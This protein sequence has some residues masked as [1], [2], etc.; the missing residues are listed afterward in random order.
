[1]QTRTTIKITLLLCL[2]SVMNLKA[3]I[4]VGTSAP[5]AA[6]DI[7]STTQGVLIP[8]LAALQAEAISNPELGELIYSTTN[9][10]V[11]IKSQGFWYY[12]GTTWKPFGATVQ[13]NIDLY[14]GNGTLT[15]NRTVTMSGNNLSFDSDK[16]TILS[17]AQ[18][19]GLGNNTP[20][21][22]LDVNGNTR[23]R[24]LSAGNVVSL[25]DGT[26]ALGPKVPYGTVKESLRST[27]HNGWYKLDGRAV[28]TLSATAQARA[29]TLGITGNLINASN[30][31]MRQG[32]TLASGGA[33]NVTLIRANLPNYNM[34]GTTSTS[35]DQ[36]HTMIATGF[37]LTPNA[38]GNAFIVRAGRG[39]ASATATIT[40]ASA[41]AHIHS[42]NITSGGTGTPFSI[43]PESITYTYFIYLGQ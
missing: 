28:N 26:L 14:N 19:V 32:A 38:A 42:G 11:T 5:K 6:L 3:Q 13:P 40:V 22:T 1:M 41:G 17:T 31:L 24:N 15:S 34:T 20:Q 43:I 18:R 37:N 12:D 2:F 35:A 29:A 7:T 39:T 8:R 21:H 23:V 36:T 33:S 10:G 27:D 25:A 4:G 9:D 30:L 16:L